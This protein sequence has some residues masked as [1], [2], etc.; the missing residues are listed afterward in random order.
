MRGRGGGAVEEACTG[1]HALSTNTPGAAISGQLWQ[2]VGCGVH[3]ARP[4]TPC[5]VRD[6]LRLVAQGRWT[7][8]T[9]ATCSGAT[10]S[11]RCV[12]LPRKEEGFLAVGRPLRRWAP[13]ARSEH[14]LLPRPRPVPR[15]RRACGRLQIAWW[16]IVLWEIVLGVGFGA[17]AGYIYVFKSAMT[18]TLVSGAWCTCQGGLRGMPRTR[19]RGDRSADM[20]RGLRERSKAPRQLYRRQWIRCCT[21]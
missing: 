12:L 13:L 11:S 5:R 17:Y 9:T 4:S 19:H 7:R 21:K 3:F 2:V 18:N 10:S 14:A 8:R 6:A 16:C 1:R 20:A 15:C